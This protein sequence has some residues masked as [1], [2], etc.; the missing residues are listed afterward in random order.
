MARLVRHSALALWPSVPTGNGFCLYI[1]RTCL[2]AVGAFDT[3]AF[4]RGYGEENDFC[5]RAGRAG[6]ENL[7]DD[8]T[9]VWHRR[10]ASFGQSRFAHM[11]AGRAVLATRYPE[12]ASMVRMFRTDPA[13]LTIRWRIRRALEN[14][15]ETAAARPRVLFVISTESGGTPQT[16]SDL[17]KAL[18]DRYEPWVLRTDGQDVVLSRHDVTEPVERHRLTRPMEPA[19]HRSVEYDQI[20]AG[21]LLRHGFELVHIRHLAWHGMG[22]RR[23]AAP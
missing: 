13:F 22:C 14:A 11:E 4:P 10:S 12:Y 23:Y 5:M 18:A 7:V 17:M 1:R 20:V 21:L 8:R 16:N 15:W 19:T 2:D 9:Y 6:F 3:A